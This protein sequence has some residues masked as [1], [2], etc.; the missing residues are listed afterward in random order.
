MLQRLAA[1]G[2]VTEAATN[3]DFERV[4]A[5]P[6]WPELEAKTSGAHPKPAAVTIAPP[7][8]RRR[9]PHS[10]PPPRRHDREARCDREPRK[11]TPNPSPAK[12]NAREPKGQTASKTEGPL[13]F[14]RPPA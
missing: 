3:N 12:P 13:V 9:R 11:P 14:L 6:G 1:M 4:R 10:A 5:L 7:K 8:V 2:V